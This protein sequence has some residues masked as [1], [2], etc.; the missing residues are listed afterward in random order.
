M[1]LLQTKIWERRVGG[2]GQIGSRERKTCVR[3][4]TW[5]VSEMQK[6]VHRAEY[7]LGHKALQ[8]LQ[9]QVEE[10]VGEGERGQRK[11]SD[12]RWELAQ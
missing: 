11:G 2:R 1:E 12:Q 4:K 10:E 6:E 5:S 8:K 9:K 7:V 3:L